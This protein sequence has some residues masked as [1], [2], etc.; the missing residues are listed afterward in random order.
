MIDI[1]HLWIGSRV[2][3]RNAE[4]LERQDRRESNARTYARKLRI[5][6]GKAEGIL[7]QDVEGRVY[8]DC[9][10]G[11][12]ALALGH[13]HPAVV[14][15]I[16]RAL[17]EGL[18][19]QTLDLMTPLKDAFTEALFSTLPPEFAARSRIQFRGPAGTDA[20]EAAIKLVKTATGKNALL[21][22]N[23]G[24]YGMSQGALALMGDLS[25][26]TDLG[27]LMP[28]VQFLPFPHVYRCPF[29]VGGEETARLSAALIRS[30]LADPEGGVAPAGMIVELVQGEGGVIPGPDSW[31][32]DIR[33]ITRE[34]GVPLVVDEIQTGW[35]RTGRFYAL[36]HSGIIPDVLVLSKAIGGG[37][38]LAVI[39]YDEDLDTWRP[40]AHAGTFRGNQ[41]AMATGLATLEVIRQE[42]LVAHASAM[43]DRLAGNLRSLQA[44]IPFIGHV[45]HRGLMV[46]AEIVDPDGVEDALGHP[47]AYSDAACAIQQECLKRGLILDLSGRFGAVARFLPP[48]II[49]AEQVDHVCEIFRDACLAVARNPIGKVL[50]T[51]P[52]A[53]SGKTKIP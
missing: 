25:P 52:L 8:F 41:L 21:T 47:P 7:V 4:Y 42:G 31:I 17:D 19:F 13:N 40:G 15:A 48:L 30:S 33:T 43:G 46:G 12:G 34:R 16:H 36:E 9:L 23:G 14:A 26:K 10:A 35:G 37:L 1:D 38:P 20:V 11:A 18:P 3:S 51:A 5:A 22:F 29:G 27:G 44:E 32:L 39:V 28:G 2:G 45:R 49:T 53:R 24:Y 50:Q 6:I